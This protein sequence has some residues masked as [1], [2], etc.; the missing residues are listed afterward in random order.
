M[1]HQ[2]FQNILSQNWALPFHE[3]D[4]AKLITVKLKNLRKG[5]REWQAS[6]RSIK[7]VIANV[8]I[9]IL[10]VEVLAD[11]RDLS[12]PEWNFHKMLKKHLL[13]LLEKQRLYWKQRG[14][15]KWVQLGDA[16]TRF[17]HANASI[18]HR[19]NLI[20]ELTS[21]AQVTVT[22]HEKKEKIL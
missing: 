6:M 8:R 11:Q 18:R 3:N 16:S 9:V 14:N 7:T 17:F 19:S 12:I 21:R 20:N 2:D 1:K 10:F 15:V 5:L 4:K 22:Q 13:D